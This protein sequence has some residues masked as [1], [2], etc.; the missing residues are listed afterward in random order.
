MKKDIEFFYDVHCGLD[1]YQVRMDEM[2]TPRQA[3]DIIMQHCLDSNIDPHFALGH[4]CWWNWG[5]EKKSFRLSPSF[6]E[7]LKDETAKRYQEQKEK[8]KHQ[9]L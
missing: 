8:Y 3:Y 4:T 1:V 9:R 6:R 5:G 2:P 7:E